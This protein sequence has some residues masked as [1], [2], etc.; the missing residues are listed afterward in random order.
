MTLVC[1]APWGDRQYSLGQGRPRR[2]WAGGRPRLFWAVGGGRSCYPSPAFLAPLYRP[3][4][5]RPRA[6]TVHLR[7]RSAIP[8]DLDGPVVADTDSLSARN[9]AGF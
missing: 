3:L 9:Q 7:I 8:K 6:N 4:A 1:C 2:Y 5:L